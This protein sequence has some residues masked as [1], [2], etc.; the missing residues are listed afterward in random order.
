MRPRS[1]GDRV[2]QWLLAVYPRAFRERFGA[3]LLRT[4]RDARRGAAARRGRVAATIISLIDFADVLAGGLPER[5]R[6]GRRASPHTPRVQRPL[7]EGPMSLF[8]QDLRFAVRSLGKQ[9]G[10]SAVVVVTVALGVGAN[11]A[12]FGIVKGIL[13]EPL[14]YAEPQ[15][16]A[17]VFQTDRMNNTSR[18]GVSAPDY[19]DW[20]ERQRSFDALAAYSGFNPTLGGTAGEPERVSVSLVTHT[21]FPLLGW[22]AETGRTFTP[23]EDVPDGPLVALLSHGL[24]QRQFGGVPTAI[25]QDLLLDGDRYTIV[26]VMPAAFDFPGGSDVWVPA[27]LGPT[28]QSRGM[29]NLIALGRL[30]DGVPVQTADRDMNRIMAELEREYPDD[31]VGRGANVELLS[32]TVT[33]GVRPA[34]LLL[35]GAVGL[36]LLIT[37]ANV[38][39]LLLSRGSARRR[40]IAVRAALGAGRARLVGRV[41]SESTLLGLAGGALGVVLAFAGV[42]ALRALDPASVP[43]LDNVGIDVPVLGFALLVAIGTGLV[44]GILPAVRSSGAPLS[45]VLA[46]GGRSAGGVRTGRLRSALAVTQ[47]AVAFVLVV[48]AGLLIKSMWNLMRVDPGFRAE[49]MVRL[50]VSLPGARYPAPFSEWPNAPLVYRFHDAVL[51][52]A[53]RLPYVTGAALALNHPMNPGWTTRITIEGG[54]TTVEEGV[55]EERIRPVS[56]GYFATAGIPLRTGRDFTSADRADAPPVVIVN[57]AFVRKYFPHEA[58]LGRQIQF[59]GVMRQIVGI[60]ADVR[61][62]GLDEPTRP[63][64]YGAMSQLPFTAFDVLLRGNAPPQQMIDAMRAEIHGVDPQL[65]IFNTE[66]LEAILRQSLGDRRFNMILLGAFALLALSLASVGIYGVISYGV[67][68]RTHEFGIRMSLGAD[69]RRLRYHVLTQGL[70]LTVVGLAIG[71]VGAIAAARAIA[72]LLYGVAA[73][74]PLTLVAVT[75]FL[76]LVALAAS[77]LPATRASRVDPLVALRME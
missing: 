63:A 43:R 73:V 4:M 71:L 29:H 7:R 3:D 28:S 8:L 15:E 31:N 57:E 54:P 9:P 59:W 49:Q 76:C 23:D 69:P 44:F 21:L 18:E 35:M 34:L 77:L 2:A 68:R 53:N 39:N 36:V 67:S 45:E 6:A 72:G 62:M 10:F 22:G 30:S 64:V 65:A 37:C 17:V 33:G 19:F 75:V 66:S 47:V 32:A 41:L 74:D 50:S 25:G 42:R 60:A 5:V 52:R 56:A 40:E 13:L 14:P 27:R 26:G 46:E 51:E 38:A 61:F 20:L 12:M 1:F 48:G 24:W 70:R 11:T 16:L 58:P 55:E